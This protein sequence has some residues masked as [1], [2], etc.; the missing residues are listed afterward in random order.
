MVHTPIKIM[1]VSDTLAFGGLEKIVSN[2]ARYLDC[3]SFDFSACCFDDGG[4]YAD[5]IKQAGKPVYTLRRTP[6]VDFQ[7]FSKL[8]RLFR[9]TKIDVLHT[10]NFGPLF[11]SVLPA[12]LAGVKRIIHTDHA[13]TAF[14]DLRRRM[15][16]ERFLAHF[17]DRIIAVSPQVKRDLVRYEN[18]PERKIEIVWNGVDHQLAPTRSAEQMRAELQIAHNSL[19]IGVCCRL[20]P[21]KG[22]GYFLEAV[23]GILR[24]NRNVIFLIAG[25]GP[26]RTELEQTAQGLDISGRVKFLG[27][28]SD[29]QNILHAI[30]AYVLPS[31]HEGTPLGLLEAMSL[32]KPVIVT[33]VGSNAEIIEDNVS[34]RLVEPR[35]PSD[36]ARTIIDVL[37]HPEMAL[38]MGGAARHIAQDRFSLKRMVGEYERIYKDLL[39]HRGMSRALLNLG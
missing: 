32:G 38:R 31:V 22:V 18:I 30:D 26:L 15:L 14:P 8:Y 27:F 23:P 5:E 3:Q 7:L 11:Y 20:V 21:Q 6:G 25:D 13:R 12:R 16:M 24:W 28:R 35:D 19:V 36:L 9:Q 1:H 39:E 29:V 17:V 37:S 34:G 33:R 2:L 4:V 10:H